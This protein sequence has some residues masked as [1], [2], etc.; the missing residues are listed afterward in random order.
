MKKEKKRHQIIFIY[1]DRIF[2]CDPTLQKSL[3]YKMGNDIIR[4]LEI[5][6]Q[7]GLEKALKK[8]L[9][10]FLTEDNETLII[11]NKNT[12]FR[13]SI[14]NPQI[15]ATEKKT[16]IDDFSDLVPFDDI[17]V[18]Q[19][20]LKK[21]IEILAINREFYE[22]ILNTLQKLN[23]NITM[24][25]PELVVE[26]VVGEASCTPQENDALLKVI[27]KLGAYD[28]LGAGHKLVTKYNAEIEPIKERN[29]RL[30]VLVG[31]FGFLIILLVGA[32]IFNS[33]R[34]Y[35][36]PQPESLLLD[37]EV[38]TAVI[39]PPES[40]PTTSPE[41]TTGAELATPE[42][43]SS[44][45][46]LELEQYSIRVLNGSGIV[47]QAGIV[48]DD[49]QEAGFSDIDIGNAQRIT[50]NKTQILMT[51]TLPASVRKIVLDVVENLGQ[52]YSIQENSELNYDIVI[53][54]TS[55]E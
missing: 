51:P 26:D 22:P 31:V 52:E 5:V 19:F 29:K 32:I 23:F 45:A 10:E 14:D 53:T 49:L 44:V 42:D 16:I 24:I 25:L 6:D 38:V 55:I 21:Q 35:D 20:T 2:F 18:K 15:T 39:K 43:A 50:S 4:D 33:T 48:R 13:K 41:A 40:S 28:L 17:F 8:F 27:G 54:T 47:G 7:V 30:M 3:E 12:Y 36:D 46:T 37:D 1:R 9:L 34:T 11:L